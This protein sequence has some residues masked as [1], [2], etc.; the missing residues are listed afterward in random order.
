MILGD[1]GARIIKVERPGTGDET[2]GWGPPFD[3]NGN[4]AYFNSVNR[5]KLSLAA[6]L[7]D[8]A[9]ADLSFHTPFPDGSGALGPNITGGVVPRE[10]ATFDDL[11][12]FITTG[13]IDGE[14]YG[15]TNVGSGQM[16]G[17]GDNPNTEEIE[18]DGMMP[19]EMIAAIARYVGSLPPA[20]TPVPATVPSVADLTAPD[21]EG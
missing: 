19:P 2:R 1:L 14:L 20:P 13:S 18:G 21:E 12:A 7:D 3:H 16:P 9:D 11:V 17:F 8:P 4:A 15:N 10:F 5:N 6:D